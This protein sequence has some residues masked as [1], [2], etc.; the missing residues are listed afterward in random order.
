VTGNS[1]LTSELGAKAVDLIRQ[2][3]PSAHRIGAL[4][5]LRKRVGRVR[6]LDGRSSG[7]TGILDLFEKRGDGDVTG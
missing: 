4:A 5:R 6:R 1:S 3:L 2:M 7:I